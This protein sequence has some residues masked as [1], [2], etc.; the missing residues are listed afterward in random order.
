MKKLFL[1]VSLVIVSVVSLCPVSFAAPSS[2]GRYV[3]LG[4]SVAAGAGLPLQDDSPQ[5]RACGRSAQAYP[6]AVASGLGLTHELVACGGASVPVGITGP[7]IAGGLTFATQIE[8]AYQGAQPPTHLTLTVGTNDIH[9]SDFIRKCYAATCGTWQD[10]LTVV[11]LQYALF[12]NLREALREIRQRTPVGQALPEVV[13]TGYF[14]PLSLGQP[15]CA[16]TRG[17]TTSEIS[18]A[19]GQ[20]QLL[21]N[22]IRTATTLSGFAQYAPVDFTGHELCSAD[23]WVQ[24]LRDP[25]PYHPTAAGQAAIAN[26]VLQAF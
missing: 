15:A 18:W 5:S 19:L 11:Q 8:Q 25:A 21:N 26:T 9:W 10:T 1:F 12:G 22:F 17:L 7:Q 13:V 6:S 4:D 24:G 3:A 2:A 16:D 20:E 23:P 14:Q